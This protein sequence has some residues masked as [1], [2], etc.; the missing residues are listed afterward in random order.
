MRF[1][2]D[3]NHIASL[4]DSSAPFRGLDQFFMSALLRIIQVFAA[5]NLSRNNPNADGWALLIR[6]VLYVFGQP[7]TNGR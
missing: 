4:D 3:A 6:V 2:I 5:I 7:C 1:R